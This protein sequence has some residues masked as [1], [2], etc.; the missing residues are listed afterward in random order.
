MKIA[1][2]VALGA[3][4]ALAAFGQALAQDW[5]TRSVTV[6]LPIQLPL[7]TMPVPD[8]KTWMPTCVVLLIKAVPAAFTTVYPQ[9]QPLKY[10]K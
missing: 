4:I 2:Q 10:A 8:A 9:T 7:T 1:R 6:V 3:G 5:P